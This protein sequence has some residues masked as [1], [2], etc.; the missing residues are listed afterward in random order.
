ME[1]TTATE[2]T[3]VF[4]DVLNY[5]IFTLGARVLTLAL[6]GKFFLLFG[7]VILMV[8]VVTRIFLARA[9]SRT[10]MDPS[11]QFA[12]IKIA[13]YCLI[14]LG[15]YVAL[16]LVGVELSSLAVLAGAVGVGLGFGLQNITNNF[17]CGIII[18]AERPV[19]LG[20]RVEVAN[21]A[22]RV[23]RISLRSTTVVTNDNIAIIVPNS[24]FIT[25]TVTNWSH[26][27]PRVRIRI[28]FGVAYGTDTDKLTTVLME[29]AAND[30]QVLKTP[31][32]ALFFDGFGDSSLNFELA[33]WTQEL[34]SSPRRFRS[35]INFAIDRALRAHGIEIPFPQRDLHIRSGTLQ[36]KQKPDLDASA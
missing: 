6:I 3:Q 25:Q 2:F 30:P 10:S 14:V 36:V 21:V 11:L 31:E 20:D 26:G 24:D 32:P 12:T 34:A 8:R 15:G 1:P 27:D 29:I 9:L 16:N 7:G 13:G 22:G 35:Q 17:I 23:T 18:L 19:K 33:V 28:P 5:P 4:R